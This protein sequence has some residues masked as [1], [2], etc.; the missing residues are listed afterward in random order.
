MRITHEIE[1][2]TM[3]DLKKSL[4]KKF[5]TWKIKKES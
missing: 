3:E 1:N 2:G 5:K 4:Q